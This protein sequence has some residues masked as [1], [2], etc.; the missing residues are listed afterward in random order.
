ME[1]L[2]VLVSEKALYIQTHIEPDV[3]IAGNEAY[4]RQ[5]LLNLFD[6]ACKYNR[7][8]G[9]VTVSIKRLTL[10][11]V[12]TV[13]NTGIPMASEHA[14]RVFDRF[15]RGD[16]AHGRNIDGCGLGLTIAREIA[17][18]HHASLEILPC[19]EE[20]TSFA[21]TFEALETPINIKPDE[22]AC[23]PS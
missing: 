22:Q 12:L 13:S 14:D 2:D 16:A 10:Q 18:A 3:W 1:D 7:Q 6:N 5:L 19:E 17:K 21:L 4:L 15:Y 9:Q 8:S 20:W 11:S 23:D